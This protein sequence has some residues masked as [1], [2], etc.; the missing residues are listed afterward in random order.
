MA[1]LPDRVMVITGASG[2][3]GSA[4]AA[5]FGEAG[6]RLVLVDRSLE[7]LQSLAASMTGVAEPL[8]VG[9]VNLQD[10]AAVAGIFERALGRFGRVDVL[11]NTV[12]AY[13]GG[14]PLAEEEISSWDL[15]FAV[16][17]RTTLLTCRAALPAML[18]QGAGRIIN[19]ISRNAFAGVAG[20][21]AYSAAKAAVLRLSESLA[22]EV[23]DAG[24]NVNC[25]VPGTIDTPQNRASSPA[26]DFS[27][28]VDARA[29]ADVAVF[30]ASD[31]ARAV[32]GA[33][34]PVYGRS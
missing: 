31:A 24:V 7:R 9:D 17:L 13:R 21:A 23:K 4:A 22:Q 25:V 11:F 30:L 16:N 20:A 6:A 2:N 32:T 5:A 14:T 29:I 15:V 10:G 19:T 12:G 27:R 34:L 26:A 28:W 33:A 3:L 18:R 8:L 1:L